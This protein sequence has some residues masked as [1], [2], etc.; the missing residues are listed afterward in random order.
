MDAAGGVDARASRR[1]ICFCR[2]RRQAA[3]GAGRPGRRRGC[4]LPGADSHPSL[5]SIGCPL[6]LEGSIFA[7]DRCRQGAC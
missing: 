3:G 4:Q 1:V 5:L 6:L 7:A 2:F